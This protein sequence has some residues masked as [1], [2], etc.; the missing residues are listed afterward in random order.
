MKL[1]VFFSTVFLL[2]FTLISQAQ[3]KRDRVEYDDE[4][5]QVPTEKK[6]EKPSDVNPGLIK[7]VA[8]KVYFNLSLG[9]NFGFAGSSNYSNMGGNLQ[10]ESFSY[11]SGI[12]LQTGLGYNF[13]NSVGLEINLDYQL[14]IPISVIPSKFTYYDSSLAQ[15]LTVKTELGYSANILKINPQL[16]FS[17]GNTS[18]FTPYFKIG[19][20]FGFSTRYESNKHIFTPL[21][22]NDS[23][24]QE[25]KYEDVS[26]FGVGL[27]S[28]IGGKF[29]LVE[30]AVFLFA[31]FNYTALNQSYE[32]GSMVSATQDGTSFLNRISVGDREYVYTKSIAANY[33]PSPYMASQKIMEYFNF[34]SF[35]VKFGFIF[36][37]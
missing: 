28:N 15:N 23:I 34:N 3:I 7:D 5:K 30:N 10:V 32:K 36:M 29:T 6:Q 20:V 33:S 24:V 17:M 26:G 27:T 12:A 35:G 25:Y 2:L 9:G 19:P 16:V 18:R 13:S 1:N 22:Y 37:L 31:D 4:P 14:G 11:G 21:N 8:K